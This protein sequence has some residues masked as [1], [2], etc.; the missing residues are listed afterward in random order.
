MQGVAVC[1]E[2]GLDP[3]KVNVHG[4]AVALGHPIGASGARILTTLLYALRDRGQVAR[5]RD[6]VPGRR[7][8]GR[9]GRGAGPDEGRGAR[10]GHD[11]ERDRAGLRPARPRRGPRATSSRAFLDRAL[12][13]IDKSLSQAR[14]EGEDPGRRGRDAAL[15]RI[16]TVTDLRA[17]SPTPSSS[18]RPSSRTS[19]SR[20]RLFRELDQHHRPGDDPRLEHLLDLDHQARRGHEAPRQGHRHALHEPGAADGAGRGDPRPGDLGRD[21]AHRDDALRRRW[22]RRRSR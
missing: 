16:A 22:A 4:G 2:L 13:T 20:P 12:A 11:G 9:P 8:R 7:Q 10:R 6:A 21:D 15:A 3:A 19:R 18:S 5:R 14:G 17:P 1:R